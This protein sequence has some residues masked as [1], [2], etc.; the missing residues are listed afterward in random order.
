MFQRNRQNLNA[1]TRLK[2]D[3]IVPFLSIRETVQENL[4]TV[5]ALRMGSARKKRV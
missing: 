5:Y 3:P 2:S 1:Q 4:R